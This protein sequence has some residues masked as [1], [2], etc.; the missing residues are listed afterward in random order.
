M[1]RKARQSSRKR[2]FCAWE[3]VAGRLVFPGSTHSP[4]IF[5]FRRAHAGC[6]D[7]GQPE[8]HP[9]TR[10]PAHPV[11]ALGPGFAALAGP[12]HPL[13]PASRSQRPARRI[14]LQVHN[15]RPFPWQFFSGV[16]SPGLRTG[17]LGRPGLI[18][19]FLL[20]GLA[21]DQGPERSPLLCGRLQWMRPRLKQLPDPSSLNRSNR[22]GR[23]A[24]PVR[25]RPGPSAASS[26]AR[27]R[28]STHGSARQL[29]WP[30]AP[31]LPSRPMTWCPPVSNDPAQ[32]D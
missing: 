30:I 6:F 11:A 2:L 23:S 3:M 16:F 22:S 18:S 9:L 24:R 1:R 4:T 20:T 32:L 10:R 21:V 25:G 13:A 27:R 8:N 12:C 17:R 14:V 26:S 29:A 7:E 19:Q 15:R 28:R 31:G 5:G